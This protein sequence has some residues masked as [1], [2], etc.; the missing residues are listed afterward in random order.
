MPEKYVENNVL[1]YFKEKLHKIIKA[2]K[3]TNALIGNYFNA[4]PKLAAADNTND[5]FDGVLEM[6]RNEIKRFKAS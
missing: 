1:Y 3:E 6:V 2:K 5:T 4:H